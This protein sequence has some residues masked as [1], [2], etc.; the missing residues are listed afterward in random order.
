MALCGQYVFL[1]SYLNKIKSQLRAL[2]QPC[3]TKAQ[4]MGFV[5]AQAGPAGPPV[6]NTPVSSQQSTA[7][8]GPESKQTKLSLLASSDPIA[9]FSV[10]RGKHSPAVS[11]CQQELLLLCH[12]P[13]AV[14]WDGVRSTSE[15][16][17]RQLLQ[18]SWCVES[19]LPLK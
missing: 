11:S 14:R 7:L 6:R 18:T 15:N 17:G 1:K 10:P 4:R 12:K 3:S 19:W 5:V 13:E 16:R 8:P 2:V 9:C